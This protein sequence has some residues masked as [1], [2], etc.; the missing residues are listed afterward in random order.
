MA[1]AAVLLCNYF[2]TAF[3]VSFYGIVN[4]ITQQEAEKSEE[5]V[6]MTTDTPVELSKTKEVENLV[7]GS[8]IGHLAD[9]ILYLFQ[10]Q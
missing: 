4:V 5:E 2:V 9:F 6:L 7:S 1:F 8:N 3:N 10:V